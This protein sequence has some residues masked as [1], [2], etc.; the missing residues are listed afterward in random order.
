M[1][2]G[3]FQVLNLSQGFSGKYIKDDAERRD[4]SRY[5]GVYHGEWR[6]DAGPL[7]KGPIGISWVGKD[8]QGKGEGEVFGMSWVLRDVLQGGY[9]IARP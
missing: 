8:A 5:Q 4:R 3:V 2:M 6:T 9:D 7:R 1:E